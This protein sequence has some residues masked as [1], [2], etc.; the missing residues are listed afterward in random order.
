MINIILGVVRAAIRAGSPLLVGTL[1][2]IYTER[3]GVLNLGVEGV[4]LMGAVSAFAVTQTTGS[5]ALGIIAAM[6]VGGLM[7]LLHGFMS[8]TLKVNQYVVGLSLVM[9]GSGV[10]SLIGLGYIGIR[11]KTLKPVF[12]GF[13]ILVYLFIALAMVLWFILYRTRI[14][15]EIRSV[16][17]NPAA[18]DA[19]GI[20]VDRTRYMCTI[21]GSALVGLAGAYLSTAYLSA[22]TDNMTNGRGWIILALTI[23][24]SWDP[25]GAVIGAW[26]FGGVEALQYRLQPLGISPSL[27]GMLPFIATIVIL[28]VSGRLSKGMRGAPEALGKPYRRGER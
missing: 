7:G 28:V 11:G 9:V 14:G 24:A 22:W 19:M 1:G 15:I 16:G 10:S 4:M 25:R 21:F 8:V 2:E 18:T 3:A 12:L 23:F 17:E 27:L 13:D 6:L 20:N 26:I 5:I